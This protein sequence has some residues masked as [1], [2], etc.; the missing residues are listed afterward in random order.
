MSVTVSEYLAF[1][2]YY[3]RLVREVMRLDEEKHRNYY[4]ALP[5]AEDYMEL[6]VSYNMVLSESKREIVEGSLYCDSKHATGNGRL[7]KQRSIYQAIWLDSGWAVCTAVKFRR[8][9]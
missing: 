9:K 6:M 5:I 4:R 3:N 8:R 2:R 7:Q 1:K